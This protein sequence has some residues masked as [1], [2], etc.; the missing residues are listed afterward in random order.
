MQL[1][2]NISNPIEY[3]PFELSSEFP[4]FISKSLHSPLDTISILHYHNCLEIGYCY[5]GE[6]LFF[7]ENKVFS[8]SRGNISIIFPNQVHI[9]QSASENKSSWRFLLIDPEKL[10]ETCFCEYLQDIVIGSRGTVGF[11]NIHSKESQPD[12]VDL[13]YKLI[14]TL[15]KEEPKYQMAAKGLTLTLLSKISGLSDVGSKLNQDSRDIQILKVLPALNFIFKN[16][17]EV[18]STEKLAKVCNTSITSFRRYFSKII[19]SSPQDYIIK[20]RIQMA[21]VLLDN[22]RNSI[23]DISLL[24]GYCSISSFNRHFK[25]LTGVS[26]KQWRRSGSSACN[27]M[28]KKISQKK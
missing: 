3:N 27:V 16:Y 21:T 26:P 6:G 22:T 5:E 18:I 1:Q 24:I 12:M 14:E 17:M 2:P 4:A 10:L 8:F 7:I 23:L 15:I 25:K 11:L 9:A 13:V 19:K 20:I 28:L